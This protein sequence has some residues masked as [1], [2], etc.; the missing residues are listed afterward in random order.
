MDQFSKK[1]IAAVSAIVLSLSLPV[2]ADA[3]I[4]KD[5]RVEGL[6]RISAGTV[7]NYLPLQ[8]DQRLDTDN[9]GELIR[10]LYKTGFFKDV[11]LQRQGNVLI[12]SVIERPAIAS[13]DVTGNKSLE[14][15]Q[16]T[17]ALK[18][19]GLAEGRVFNRSILDKIEQELKR[20]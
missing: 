15:E 4:V 10:A 2:M 9:S 1:I 20:Q 11:R 16:L 6:Q 19:I 14:T 8:I 12:V 17:I 18:D 5:I 7:F 3:F 13:I